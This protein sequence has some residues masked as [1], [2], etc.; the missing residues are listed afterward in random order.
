MVP[1]GIERAAGEEDAQF[2]RANPPEGHP[3]HR[4]RVG[5]KVGFGRDQEIR[6]QHG[7][8]NRRRHAAGDGHSG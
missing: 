7:K 4:H 6:G 5:R 1:G 3:K 2:G 8:G